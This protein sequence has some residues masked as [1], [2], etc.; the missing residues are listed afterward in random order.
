MAY[1]ASCGIPG[2]YLEFG[3]YAGDSFTAAYHFAAA[4]HLATMRF[5]AFDSFEGMPAT[6]E[7]DRGASREHREG[8]Y[9]C[10]RERFGQILLANG[11]DPRRVEILEGWYDDILT[12]DLKDKLPIDVAAVI[13]A[14]CCLYQ[15]T[16]CVLD[17]VDGYVQDGTIIIFGDWF[18]FKGSPDRGQRRAFSEWLAARPDVT[19]TEFH[20]FG[21]HGT[22]FIL[23]RG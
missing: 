14:D 11:V 3:V 2:D 13:S 7:H 5:Y 19:A 22:S 1:A 12:A 10:D 17:F 15:S 18:S 4:N 6:M 8:G 23:H 16:R 21:W 9:A 20:K